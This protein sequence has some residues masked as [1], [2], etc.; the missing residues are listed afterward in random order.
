MGPFLAPTAAV[1]SV[2]RQ[3]RSACVIARRRRVSIRPKAERCARRRRGHLSGRE[4]YGGAANFREASVLLP[5]IGGFQR[6]NVLLALV[7]SLFGRE[8]PVLLP[9]VGVGRSQ[10]SY[11]PSIRPK[12]ERLKRALCLGAV[13]R[14]EAP[15]QSNRPVA[16]YESFGEVESSPPAGG[17]SRQ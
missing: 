11:C 8:A 9:A 13:V 16:F 6:P 15:R 3:A 1:R 14:R 5:A 4:A 17:S 2:R 7:S 12:A 10:T